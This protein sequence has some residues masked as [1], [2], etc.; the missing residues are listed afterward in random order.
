MEP[1]RMGSRKYSRYS[2]QEY[3]HTHTL[4]G[5]QGRR[6]GRERTVLWLFLQP[7]S[8]RLFP[9]PLC[10][11]TVPPHHPEL[12]GDVHP[13]GPRVGGNLQ[14]TW[15]LRGGGKQGNYARD[16]K[17]TPRLFH[18]LAFPPEGF[19]PNPLSPLSQAPPT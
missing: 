7:L 12:G 13:S 8:V 19:M 18:A 15:G 11:V 3:E 2:G 17:A 4:T 6:R 9:K 16:V 14:Y 5:G 1:L 10:T